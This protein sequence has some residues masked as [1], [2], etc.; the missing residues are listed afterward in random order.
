M[1]R[2]RYVMQFTDAHRR[3]DSPARRIGCTP[4]EFAAR[5]AAGE[6]W[7]FG[8]RDWHD[9]GEFGPNRSTA[10]GLNTACRDYRRVYNRRYARRKARSQEQ[11]R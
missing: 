11:S 8:C 3:V 7:C 1:I 2:Q 10:D 6:K 5:K 4:A 9:R